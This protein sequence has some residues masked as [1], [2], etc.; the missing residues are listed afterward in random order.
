[1]LTMTLALCYLM[2]AMTPNVWPSFLGIGHS[3]LDARTLPLTWSPTKNIAWKTQLPGQGQSCPVIWGDR[4]FV[5]SISGA[6]KDTCHVTAI[7][8]ANG[9][10]IWD[11]TFP[12][13]QKTPSSYYISRAAP[14]PV[15]DAE[16]VYAFFE[17]GELVAIG[18]DGHV[19]WTRSLVR[20]YGNFESDHGLAASLTQTGDLIFVLVEHSGPSY[21]LAVDKKTGKNAWKIERSSRTSWASPVVLRIGGKE[22]VVINSSGS[23]DGYDVNSGRLLWSY[24]EVGGNISGI[25][26]PA[27]SD[28]FLVHASPGHK[29][30]Y[31]ADAKRSN[32]LLQIQRT[33][34]GAYKPTVRWVANALPSFGNPIVHQNIAYWVNRVGIV[35][36]FELETGKEL[37]SERIAESCWATPLAV[38]DRIYFFGKDGT[39][40]VIKAGPRFEILANN[41]LWDKDANDGSAPYPNTERKPEA[42]LP[43]ANTSGQQNEPNRS[44]APGQ[45]QGRPGPKGELF[46]DPIQYGVA[47]VN[48]SLIIRTGQ[49]VYCIR[50]SR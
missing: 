24:Q 42:H 13:T 3:P 17:T 4:V 2:P 5:T 40:T 8:L 31:L 47:A 23:V 9:Q 34:E 43:P 19:V 50:E 14:S 48:G 33:D 37:Y 44:K 46:P 15:V 38:G 21:L 12:S 11:R 30:Q 32:L 35:S 10:V 27:G 6:N 22:Q 29:N 20:E 41:R 28:S 49:V 1:M 25:A 16:R 45:R 39:T 36:A 26:Y 18:H 7:S